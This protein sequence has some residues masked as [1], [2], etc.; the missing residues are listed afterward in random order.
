[1]TDSEKATIVMADDH[2]LFAEGLARI[3][4]PYVKILGV[5]LDGRA[6]VEQ[7][8]AKRPDIGLL[9][10]AMPQLNGIEAARELRGSGSHTR[11]VFVT[12]KTEREYVRAA[13]QAGACGYVL[14]Q[15]AADELLKAIDAVKKGE[16]YLS[17]AIA[18]IIG[19]DPEMIKHD[20]TAFP[21]AEL[22]PRQLEVLRLLAEGNAAKEIAEALDISTKTVEFHKASIMNALGRRTT[23][24]LTR[25]AVEHGLVSH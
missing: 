10:V 2:A 1:M 11:I 23:A 19:I 5:A 20:P 12:Q 4:G 25:Y 16:R 7:V 6:F 24:E 9:D 21:A 15:A 18:R 3:L 17:P 14:K 13:V 8:M 22:T